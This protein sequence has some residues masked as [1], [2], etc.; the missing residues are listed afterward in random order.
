MKALIAFGTCLACL[1]VALLSG[2]LAKTAVKALFNQM[3]R[4][5]TAARAEAEVVQLGLANIEAEL[6]PKLPIKLDD[7]FSM[8]NVQTSGK[9]LTYVFLVTTAADATY[10]KHQIAQG[11]AK[12][13]SEWC[14]NENMRASLKLGAIIRYQ[15]V[16]VRDETLALIEITQADCRNEQATSEQG[17]NL[18][19]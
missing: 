12:I 19:R 1:M 11:K 8:I 16:N 7:N 13:A 10:A 3:E 2:D 9:T 6:E 18:R 4:S 17:N 15:Y 14:D 5:P